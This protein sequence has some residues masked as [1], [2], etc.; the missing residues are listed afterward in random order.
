MHKH[1]LIKLYGIGNKIAEDIGKDSHL[2]FAETELEFCYKNNIQILLSHQGNFPGL[3]HE[4]DDAPAIENLITK[5]QI[6]V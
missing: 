4:C 5:G 6:L 1:E 3:L 2:Q